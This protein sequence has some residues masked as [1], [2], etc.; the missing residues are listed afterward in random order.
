MKKLLLLTTLLLTV[1]CSA[2]IE[3][4]TIDTSYKNYA[5]IIQKEMSADDW[6]YTYKKVEPSDRNAYIL[7]FYVF[8]PSRSYSQ[9]YCYKSDQEYKCDRLFINH[10]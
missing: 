8:E 9:W 6:C 7:D 5:E 1:A 3:T 2:N 10:L 4:P